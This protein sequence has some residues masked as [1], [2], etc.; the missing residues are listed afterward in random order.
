MDNLEQRSNA[1]DAGTGLEA[2]IGLSDSLGA[3]MKAPKDLAR[4]GPG[5]VDLSNP[6]SYLQDESGKIC[7]LDGEWEL[8]ESLVDSGATA[9]VMDPETGEGI[10][11]EE[12]LGSRKGAGVPCSEWSQTAKQ[13][14]EGFV[15]GDGGLGQVQNDVPGRRRRQAVDECEQYL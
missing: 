13:R 12:S 4:S 9:C 1:S 10:P 6:L 5:F 3:L 15:S 8:M 2:S 7:S 11:V 14:P